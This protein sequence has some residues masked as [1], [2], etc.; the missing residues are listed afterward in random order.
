MR[1][2]HREVTEFVAHAAEVSCLS[3][4]PRSQKVLA[5]AGNEG[6][7][8]IW[9]I[10]D[11]SAAS[12]V[13]TLSSG[14]S[15]AGASGRPVT[16]CL[17]FDGDEQCVVSGSSNGS[18]KVFDLNEGKLARNLKGHQVN[19]SSLHYHPHGEI[20]ASGSADATM[21]VWDARQKSCI[22][23]YSAHTA[24]LN[25]VRFSP[26]GR[27]VASSANDGQILLWDLNAGKLLQKVRTPQSAHTTQFEFNPAEFLMAAVT[28]SKAVRLF[29]LERM[30][31]LGMCG[32]GGAGESFAAGLA[33]CGPD[34]DKL[35]VAAPAA[36]R[37]WQCEPPRLLGQADGPGLDGPC[38]VMMCPTNN[39]NAQPGRD[40]MGSL[41]MATHS[42]NFVS[43][44]RLNLDMDTHS[45]NNPNQQT[46][47]HIQA[48]GNA[49]GSGSGSAGRA[50]GRHDGARQSPIAQAQPQRL[51][52]YFEDPGEKREVK[53]P[54]N[55]RA[56]IAAAR[57]EAKAMGQASAYPS[58]QVYTPSSNSNSGVGGISSGS[59]SSSSGS[60]SSSS[61][62]SSSGSSI[63]E[64][65]AKGTPDAKAYDPGR[66]QLPPALYGSPPPAAPRVRDS[67][68]SDLM[69][70]KQPDEYEN[71]VLSNAVGSTHEHERAAEDK[72]QPSAS[73]ASSLEHRG[74]KEAM[75]AAEAELT[76]C[77]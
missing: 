62:S 14:G 41:I 33:F 51:P 11:P 71:L 56:F 7:I 35:V 31:W 19:V 25:C 44:V 69:R 37:L 13:W 66:Y 49:R 18:V 20:I 68:L 29:D 75:A 4:S 24:R 8:N 28:S 16:E 6:K 12:N 53:E 15:S 64:L 60:S 65:S 9:N 36:V 45:A 17:C 46:Q 42:S 22:Q 1:Q 3:I 10:S 40:M 59:S 77:V 2:F 55:A 23:T 74:A 54:P 34:F 72:G 63:D 67:N 70:Q 38:S 73:L 47:P 26:D 58:A 21:K 52:E 76:R 61:S 32:G 27:W 50:G 48:N 43:V 5:T 39:S 57:A 30:E